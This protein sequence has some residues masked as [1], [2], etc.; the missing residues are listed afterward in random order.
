MHD[1]DARPVVLITWGTRFLWVELF[2]SLIV[3]MGYFHTI[4]TYLFL[5]AVLCLL[6]PQLF[7]KEEGEVVETITD[8][9]T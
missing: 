3:V 8:M 9:N 7:Y 2:I 4:Y 6:L 5:G 1:P